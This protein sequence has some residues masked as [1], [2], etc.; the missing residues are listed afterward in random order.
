MIAAREAELRQLRKSNTDYEQQNAILQKHMENMQAAV[1]KL[2]A[3]TQQKKASNKMM[4]SHLEMVRSTLAVAFSSVPIPGSYQLEV[5]TGTSPTQL[6]MTHP[7][8]GSVGTVLQTHKKC[9]CHFWC[10]C[11]HLL[12][13]MQHYILSSCNVTNTHHCVVTLVQRVLKFGFSSHLIKFYMFEVIM[14]LYGS[15][16][17]LW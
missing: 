13:F 1:D 16:Y 9:F 2:N 5:H 7:V 14:L 11:L 3:E 4:Q 8:M 10:R 17:S 15:R 12:L 6:V